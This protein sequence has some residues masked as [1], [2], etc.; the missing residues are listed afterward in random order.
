MRRTADVARAVA[1]SAAIALLVV[2]LPA[3]LLTSVGWPLPRQLP[4]LSEIADTLTGHQPLETTTVWKILAVIL[5]LAW[6]QV[7]VAVI[8]ESVSVARGSMPR[9]IPGLNLAQGLVAPLVATIVLAWPAGA[10]T[11]ASAA[12]APAIQRREPPAAKV[13]ETQPPPTAEPTVVSP[14]APTITEHVVQRRD[15]LWDL[16]ERYLGDGY[17]APEIFELNRGRPQSDGRALTDPSLIRPGWVL[18]IPAPSATPT[19]SAQTVTVE[20]GDTLWDIA[21][22]ELHDGHRFAEL[23]ELNEGRP[24]ADGDSLTDPNVIEPGWVL[25]L[26]ATTRTQQAPASAAP[27]I[28]PIP[29]SPQAPTA[30]TPP[31]PPTSAPPPTTAPPATTVPTTTPNAEHSVGAPAHADL[32]DDATEDESKPLPPLGLIGGG[33]ATAGILAVLDRRR[34][35]QQRRRGRGEVPPPLTNAQRDT[36]SALRSGA[37]PARATTV[38]Q[39]TRA[40]ASRSGV[41]GLPPIERVEVHDDRVALVLA[42][43][44]PAPPGFAPVGPTRW[45]TAEPSVLSDTASASPAPALVPVGTGADANEVLIDL[46]NPAVTT[47]T[48]DQSA[49]ERFANALALAAGTSLWAE[50]TNILVIGNRPL[51]LDDVKQIDSLDTALDELDARAELVANA[52]DVARCTSLAQARAAGV[53]PDLWTPLVVI[54]TVEPT[55][56]QLARVRALAERDPHGVALVVR[57]DAASSIGRVIDI[58]ASGTATVDLDL[59]VHAHLIDDAELS[60]IS[61][62]LDQ[63][64][65]DCVGADGVSGPT[66]RRDDRGDDA[67]GLLHALIADLDILLRVLGEVDAI[68]AAEPEERLTVPKQKSLEAVTYLGLRDTRVDREDLQ[69]A[70][71]PAGAN[72]AKTFHNTIWAARKMLAQDR[73]GAELLPEPLEG[74]YQLSDRVGTDYGLFHELTARAEEIED[75]LGAADLL[76]AALS[77]VRGEPFMGVGRG[78]AWAAPHAGLIVAQ[79][80]DAAEE[81]AEI[82]LAAGDWRGAEWAARQGLRVFPCEERLYRLLMRAAHSAG[83]VPGVHRAFQELAAA[84]ADPDDGV[85]PDDTLHPETVALLE[86]LTGPRPRAD[87]ASA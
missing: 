23:V 12:P 18:Q 80:V 59:T 74:H 51:P 20:P 65:E 31:P 15:T 14:A 58:D 35:A 5:W 37:D 70:L 81:L 39:A 46:E 53:T 11:R 64:D 32:A 36:D 57:G 52:L 28:A 40:A 44:A 62:L 34:R 83:S 24:Q 27:A 45:E 9:S 56:P 13:V 75:P 67:A 3:L 43:P 22:D 77:L 26:P 86:E 48:G 71:W 4:H 33:I 63:A 1:A 19:A 61:D 69:A 38:D 41:A 76:A 49:A 17:R 2:G 29:S 87:R 73:D 68:R 6:L 66:R 21:A 7:L 82:R 25:D 42:T 60:G 10:A 55:Q 50:H 30:V 78:Y 16:A 84:V 47:I 72:S 79:V 54:S 8:A 85:E